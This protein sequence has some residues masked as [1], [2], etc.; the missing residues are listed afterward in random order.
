MLLVVVLVPPGLA[1]IEAARE[2]ERDRAAD[3]ARAVATTLA[4][5]PW[6]VEAVTGPDPPTALRERV[7]QVRTGARVDFITV[8]SPDGTR[9]THPDPEQVGGA[10]IGDTAGALAGEVTVEDAVGTL[11]PSVRVVA[12]VLDGGEVV[13]LVSTGVVLREVDQR[14][15]DTVGDVAGAGALGLAVALGAAWWL[16]RTVRRQTFG[17]GAPALARLHSYH[18]ALL[19]SVQA[20]LVLVA[21]DGTLVLVNDVARD[22]LALPDLAPG[23]PVITLAEH[24]LDPET[25]A[26]LASGRRTENEGFAVAGRALVVTQ[27]DAVSDGVR[28]GWVATITDRTALTHASVELDHLRMFTESL[29]AR[30]HE[31]DNRLHTVA[32]LV[33]LGQHAEAVELAAASSQ[34]SQA[35][36]DSVMDR[37][38]DTP[39]AA[40][41]LGKSAQADERGIVLD[42]DASLEVPADLVPSADLVTV[43]GNLLDNALEAAAQAPAPRRVHLAGGL[44]DGDLVLRVEDS[45]RGVD[46]AHR[47]RVFERGWSTKG[48]DGNRPYGRGLG[49]PIVRQ[50]VTRLGGHVEMA[51][52]PGAVVTVRV[53]CRGPS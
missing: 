3:L 10:F 6:L 24:G 42:V 20:G 32:L 11:G 5:D 52:G 19:H 23:T 21:S 36:A 43:V 41:V 33:E 1:T 46:P 27:V 48:H 47:E 30:S 4:T 9:Y 16:S 37:I 8:T 12:P 29:R 38:R 15:F 49:L 13:A 22:L 26:L 51:G 18:D 50:T 2:T 53:P 25:A 35:L 34:V 31:A 28:V 44:E 39:L 7:E 14:V 40:L 17:L 45:G